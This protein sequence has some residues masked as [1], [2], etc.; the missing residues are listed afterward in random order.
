VNVKVRD[1]VGNIAST[2]VIISTIYAG[3]TTGS[4][5]PGCNLN[6]FQVGDYIIAACNVG[7]S[8]AGIGEDSYG[9]HFQRGNNYGFPFTGTISTSS[10]QVDASSY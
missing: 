4:K 5:Y 6:D 7:T 1:A 10:T 9:H 3:V 2:G 8:Y